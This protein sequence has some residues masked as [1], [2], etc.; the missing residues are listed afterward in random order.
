MPASPT[1]MKARP[2]RPACGRGPGDLHSGTCRTVM[3]S[4]RTAS[5][6]LMKNTSR[7]DTAP[8]SQPP[9]N[10][11]MA[12]A[13]PPS[14]DQ[15]PI[16]AERSSV[17]KEA[18]RMARLPGVSSAPPTPCRARAAISVPRSAPARTAAT[19]ART[20]RRRSRT[21]AAPVAVAE[22]PAEQQQAGQRQRVGVHHPLQAGHRGV[23]VPPM[24]GSA[25]PT[26]VASRAAMPEPSTVAA[27]THR[28]R[29]VDSRSS[30]MS[31]P[32]AATVR[33][34]TICSLNKQ[35]MRIVA[36]SP[37]VRDINRLLR[38]SRARPDRGRAHAAAADDERHADR[39]VLAEDDDA[40]CVPVLTLAI[41]T[42]PESALTWR[43]RQNPG[44]R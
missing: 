33:S 43:S 34:W 1:L 19:R 18:C 25:M 31:T 6:R 10:G 23:E 21:L 37:P 3:A 9:R 16:A 20:R 11:P 28:P 41:T 7:H 40:E 8:I 35:V 27:T 38:R 2:G 4:T 14:P 15:A 5:G 30:G 39:R 26:T 29:A 24:A 42:G 36:L 22:R 17:A 44:W 32:G 12:V 13:T